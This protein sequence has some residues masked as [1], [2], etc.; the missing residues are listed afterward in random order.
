MSHNP[1]ISAR[2]S[3][4][5]SSRQIHDVNITDSVR[6]K[7]EHTSHS[8]KRLTPIQP[9]AAREDFGKFAAFTVR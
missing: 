3:R 1:R 7:S 5:I 2:P 9:A 4:R 8:G 6:P